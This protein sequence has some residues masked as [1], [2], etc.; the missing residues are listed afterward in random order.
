MNFSY[1]YG[2]TNEPISSWT[3][4]FY[5]ILRQINRI[6]PFV[7]YKYSNGYY[8]YIADGSPMAWVE[9]GSIHNQKYYTT[10]AVGNIG[11][12]FIK[13]LKLQE[14]IGYEHTVILMRHS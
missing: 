10:R 7:P 9:S 8:G 1:T 4:D 14:V 5:Q 12:E 13:G 3:G 2:N 6:A 11:Y